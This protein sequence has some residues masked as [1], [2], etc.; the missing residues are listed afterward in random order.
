MVARPWAS[1]S[2]NPSGALQ[3]GIRT[4]KVL[5]VRKV[6]RNQYFL[7]RYPQMHYYMLYISLSVS[8]QTYCTEYETPVLDEIADVTS[9]INQNIS[10]IVK[11]KSV[12][13]QAPKGHKLKA[14]LAKGSQ[15]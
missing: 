8:D 13:I 10:V 11:G 5:S 7:S 6:L 12:L 3:N 1:D 14:H 15:C 2:Q 4:A 9:A